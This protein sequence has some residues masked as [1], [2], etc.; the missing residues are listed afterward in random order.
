MGIEAVVVG[1]I[2]MNTVL[3]VVIVVCESV[4]RE[5]GE[6]GARAWL[7]V[8]RVLPRLGPFDFYMMYNRDGYYRFQ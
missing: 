8:V 4:W 7:A 1:V 6:T 3:V 2:V 5:K